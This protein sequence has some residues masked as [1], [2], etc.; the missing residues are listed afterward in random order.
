MSV[1]ATVIA[2]YTGEG[3]DQISGN[4]GDRFQVLEDYGDGWCEVLVGDS[5]GEYCVF[6]SSGLLLWTPGVAK[7]PRTD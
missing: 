6:L 2:P 5:G 1:F 7:H 3:E 4:V